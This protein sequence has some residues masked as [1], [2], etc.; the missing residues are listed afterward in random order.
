M[1]FWIAYIM[2]TL[3]LRIASFA[4]Q[5]LFRIATF[6]CLTSARNF[7]FCLIVGVDKNYVSE[8]SKMSVLTYENIVDRDRVPLNFN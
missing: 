5:L 4:C 6:T 7:S 8:L 1:L 3:L 2:C